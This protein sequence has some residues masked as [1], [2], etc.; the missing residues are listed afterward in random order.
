M[1]AKLIPGSLC[2]VKLDGLMYT[3][4]GFAMGAVQGDGLVIFS[5]INLETYPSDNDF[6]GES[7]LVRDGDITVIIKYVG[8]PERITRDPKWFKYDVYRV[9]VNGKTRMIFRQ[10]ISLV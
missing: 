1:S 4:D 2:K 6:I 9:F 3:Q 10:N 8:R 5:D 7:S